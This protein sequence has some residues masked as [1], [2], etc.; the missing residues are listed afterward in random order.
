RYARA[1]PMIP[2]RFP[3]GARRSRQAITRVPPL[4]TPRSPSLPPSA[5][6]Y[7]LPGEDLTSIRI[8]DERTK[9]IKIPN[10]S[11]HPPLLPVLPSQICRARPSPAALGPRCL[12]RRR[13][14]R[15][16]SATT[17]APSSPPPSAAPTASSPGLG[18]PISTPPSAP[19]T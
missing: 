19:Q 9:K 11:A 1:G 13:G 2:R 14:P 17:P 7:E 5:T 18:T 6:I 15:P 12:G 4:S 10:P 8:R 16:C 3:R